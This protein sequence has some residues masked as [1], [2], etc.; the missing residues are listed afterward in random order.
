[1]FGQ[2]V[3]KL[4]LHKENMV[5]KREQRL[6]LRARKII[7]E[8]RTK[9][10]TDIH[11]GT[12]FLKSLDPASFNLYDRQKIGREILA[13]IDP[14][15]SERKGNEEYFHK[16]GYRVGRTAAYS[17][18][19]HWV[20]DADAH[21][22]LIRQWGLLPPVDGEQL[23]QN[24]EDSRRGIHRK[25]SRPLKV[26]HSKFKEYH[27]KNPN[28]KLYDLEFSYLINLGDSFYKE[29]ALA[30]AKKC[31]ET[32]M[33][34]VKRDDQGNIVY[35]EHTFYLPGYGTFQEKRADLIRGEDNL[36]TLDLKKC[37]SRLEDIRLAQ[38]K[39]NLEQSLSSSS[40]SIISILVGIFF[41]SS[42]FLNY[43]VQFSPGT[44]SPVSWK[45]WL[46]IILLLI[47]IGSGIFYFKKKK[48][49]ENF[50]SNIKN[51]AKRKVKRK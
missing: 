4:K 40:L 1:M 39:L 12:A 6:S 32:A 27:Q 42:N 20:G 19:Y 23:S 21:E 2:N 38:R 43:S 9:Y 10:S 36:R 45:L 3:Y 7:Q 16:S 29:G 41:L 37:Q 35:R 48:E 13:R 47:G 28:D 11:K 15:R 44:S 24:R 33:S 22:D 18:R 30:T 31:Y 26:I 34:L 51:P 8:L 50:I 46:G 5:N 25:K 17:S 49:Q 14:F